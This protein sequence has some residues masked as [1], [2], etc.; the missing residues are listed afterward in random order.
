MQ[1]FGWMT[2]LCALLAVLLVPALAGIPETDDEIYRYLDEIKREAGAIPEQVKAL[3]RVVWLDESASAQL[4]YAAR[5]QLVGYSASTISPL[6]AVFFEVAPEHQADVVA[7]LIEARHRAEAELPSDYLPALE[8]GLWFGG[9]EA[10]RL[11]I[12][13]LTMNRYE[14]S[15]ATIIDSAYEYPELTATVVRAVSRFQLDRARHFLL[16]VMRTGT[17]EESRLAADAIV[18][19]G[20]RGLGTIREAF[21][22]EKR[23][24]REAAVNALLPISSGEDL[25]RLYDFIATNPDA[26]AELLERIIARAGMLEALLEHQQNLDAATIGD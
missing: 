10:K 4:R 17:A 8:S 6:R 11:A 12:P 15:L 1:R 22:D 25:S 16:E 23:Q 14:P 21:I 13:E 26:D 20:G 24:A 19:I 7:T 2:A 3:A 5:L 9:F 18:R